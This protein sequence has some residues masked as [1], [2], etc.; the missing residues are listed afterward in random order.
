MESYTKREIIKTIAW[1]KIMNER[2]FVM[3]KPDG[4]KKGLTDEIVT[5]I[6]RVGLRITSMRRMKL[7]RELA[8]KLY[9]VHRGRDYFEPLVD[10]TIS[11]EVVV[12]LVEGERA[13][14]RMRELIGPTDPAKAARGTIRGDFGTSTREN[15]IHAAD[16]AE[17]AELELSLFFQI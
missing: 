5:R 16:S 9:E 15:I 4:V 11:G 10:F 2:T 8:E 3:V 1:G 14:T 7:D 12:M 6:G 17:S 13:I